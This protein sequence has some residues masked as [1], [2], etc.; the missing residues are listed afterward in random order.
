MQASTCA[1]T[2]DFTHTHTRLDIAQYSLFILL[3][4]GVV[5]LWPSLELRGER[6]G[7]RGERSSVRC[8]F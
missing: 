2:D 8:D 1:A 7:E 3:Q 4:L 6:S 5:K